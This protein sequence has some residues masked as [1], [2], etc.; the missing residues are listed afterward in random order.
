MERLYAQQQYLA[1]LKRLRRRKLRQHHQN[2][3]RGGP[4][5]IHLPRN[6]TRHFLER[7]LYM[8][9]AA[10]NYHLPDP[11][12]AAFK[13]RTHAI[14]KEPYDR[15][16]QEYEEMLLKDLQA[17]QS[18]LRDSSAQ[19]DDGQVKRIV[20]VLGYH[21]E[22]GAPDAWWRRILAELAQ[23]K[24]IA[25]AY[26]RN[27]QTMVGHRLN[28]HSLQ[29]LILENP[30]MGW[31]EFQRWYGDEMPTVTANSFYFTRSYLKSQGFRLPSL[32]VA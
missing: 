1:W 15:T 16:E 24:D 22:K 13:K 3:F 28:K 2:V 5:E 23:E 18:W 14:L 21:L 17:L 10:Q 7:R 26:A 12:R 27:L 8:F 20:M 31:P 9:F 19:L 29:K 4:F 32:R 25:L 11:F 6:V 30:W